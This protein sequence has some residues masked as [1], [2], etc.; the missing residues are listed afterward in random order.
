M[1][2]Y[3]CFKHDT[4]RVF[5]RGREVCPLCEVQAGNGS[6]TEVNGRRLWQPGVDPKGPSVDGVNR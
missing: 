4:L 6:I 5:H 1:A 2:T 3:Y